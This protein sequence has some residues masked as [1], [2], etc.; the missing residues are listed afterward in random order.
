[1]AVYAGIKLEFDPLV[2][3]IKTENTNLKK[4]EKCIVT[5]EFGDDLGIITQEPQNINSKTNKTD[6]KF[7]RIATKEDLDKH[8]ISKEKELNALTVIKEKV[9]EHKLSMNTIKAHF[10]FDS[11]KILFFF[12][13][14]KRIDFRN[15]VKDLANIFRTR[16]ELRQI[17]PREATKLL[18]GIGICG[19]TLCCQKMSINFDALSVKMAKEQN[20]STNT[21]KLSGACGRLRCCLAYEH[22][23]YIALRKKFPRIGANVSFAKSYIKNS[24][25]L[26]LPNEIK[27]SVHDYNIIKGTIR[28]VL[29]SDAI[30]EVPLEG[31]K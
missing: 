20:L 12:T 25:I 7:L 27:G 26:D 9:N 5:S 24:E 1:M 15:L 2:R 8:H 14:E 22:K 29:E 21:T 23:T 17:N 28:V 31:I 16:I 10:L 13:A 30:V 3:F 19:N 6:F 11:S 4:G 18:G